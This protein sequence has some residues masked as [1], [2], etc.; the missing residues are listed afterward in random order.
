MTKLTV[1]KDS[2]ECVQHPT[3]LFCGA[4]K[5]TLTGR[6]RYAYTPRWP[7]PHHLASRPVT[8]RLKGR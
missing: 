8:I 3:L 4:T 5:D 2:K 7:T 6:L 1:F